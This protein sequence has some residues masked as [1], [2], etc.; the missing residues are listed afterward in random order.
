[1]KCQASRFD[2]Q[3]RY[4]A[5]CE[6]DQGHASHHYDGSYRDYWDDPVTT[7]NLR[8]KVALWLRS[9]LDSFIERQST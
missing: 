9:K 3:Q 2:E 7:P 5:R 4:L 6:L 1:M 8:G